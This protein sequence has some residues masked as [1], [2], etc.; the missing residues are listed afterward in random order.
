MSHS[1]ELLVTAPEPP[2]ESLAEEAQHADTPSAQR[3]SQK[4]GQAKPLSVEKDET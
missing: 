2:M 3:A 1:V 4:T